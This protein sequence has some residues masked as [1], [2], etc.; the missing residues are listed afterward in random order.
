MAAIGNYTNARKK[1]MECHTKSLAI[2]PLLFVSYPILCHDPWPPL[3]QTLQS[4]E[5]LRTTLFP[6]APSS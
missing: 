1:L 6:Y 4:L 3:M 2:G 5:F